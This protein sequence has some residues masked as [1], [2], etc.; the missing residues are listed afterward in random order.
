LTGDVTAAQDELN[1][2]LGDMGE[3]IN[4]NAHPIRWGLNLP[5]GFDAEHFPLGPNAMWDLGRALGNSPVPEV[6]M[7]EIENPIPRGSFEYLE[8]LYDWTR[9]STFAPPIAFGEDNG[10]GQRSGATLEIRLWPLIK[11]IRRGRSYLNTGLRKALYISGRILQQKG[12]DGV[13][14]RAVQSILQGHLTPHFH[15][16]LPRDQS[17]AVDEVVKLLSTDPPSISL[18]SAQSV[19]G[20]GIGEVD[21][22]IAM[23]A[24]EALWKRLKQAVDDQ[25]TEEPNPDDS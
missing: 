8:F 24:D 19:L 3:A 20:R 10:G 16:I 4:Y 22:I 17:A 5:A 21:R 7:L 9:S 2:R 25:G 6:G 11:S 13:P 23:L 14:A 1:M 18:E 12:F 15:S